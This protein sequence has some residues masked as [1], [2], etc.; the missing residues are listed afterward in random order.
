MD[1]SQQSGKGVAY[2]V[3]AYVWWGAAIFYFKFV[4]HVSAP[5]V[6]AHRII[7]SVAFLAVL[8]LFNKQYKPAVEALKNKKT[9]LYLSITTLIIAAN[10]LIFIWAIANN[11]ILDTSLGYFINP[12]V[13]IL[14]GYVFLKERLRFV[15]IICVALAL[16]GVLIQTIGFGELPII[17]ITLALSFGTYGLIRKKTPL[18]GVS[19]LAAETVLLLPFAIGFLFYLSS[20]GSLVFLNLDIKTDLLLL[21]AGIVTSLP[22]IW[23]VNGAKRLKY[24]T[25]GFIMY[26]APSMTFLSAI[27][28]YNEPL[29]ITKLISF[30]LIWLA[31]I[32][33][34]I[35]SVLR[36]RGKY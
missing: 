33:F 5:E 16:I 30:A 26:I 18:D 12:L 20:S 17:S 24:S 15:Q 2:A 29:G 3:I 14:L 21:S 1:Y 32:I 23:F 11:R 34:S 27:F 22:L 8:L 28:I 9:L 13:N 36:E 4:A 31:L 10:W 7:W 6:L 19:G 35:D 25:I